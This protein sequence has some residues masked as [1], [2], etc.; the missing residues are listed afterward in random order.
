VEELTVHLGAA[1]DGVSLVTEALRL[2]PDVIVAD[3]AMPVMSGID[4]VRKL[5]NE[6]ASRPLEKPPCAQSLVGQGGESYCENFLLLRDFPSCWGCLIRPKWIHKAD[7]PHPKS[8]RGPIDP[9]RKTHDMRRNRIE[10]PE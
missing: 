1:S 6:P 10:C 7:S 4:A 8:K 9:W 2:K 5:R 3:I